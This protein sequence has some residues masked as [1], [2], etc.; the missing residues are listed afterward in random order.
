V[1]V[2]FDLAL[3]ALLRHA[4]RDR[5]PEH[6]TVEAVASALSAVLDGGAL[7][8]GSRTLSHEMAAMPDVTAAARELERWQACAP[9]ESE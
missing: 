1:P 7:Y 2:A 3:P 4:Q 5:E 9:S 6:Q 8:V